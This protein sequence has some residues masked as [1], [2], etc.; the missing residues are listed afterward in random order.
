[1]I[2]PL[3]IMITTEIRP[4]QFQFLGDDKFTNPQLTEKFFIQTPYIFTLS[5][6]DKKHDHIISEALIDIQACES[7][8]DKF[9]SF[10]LIFHFLIPK[11]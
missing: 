3:N 6:L 4:N 5:S 2:T 9:E 8:Y 1:M 11:D 10:S 7:F